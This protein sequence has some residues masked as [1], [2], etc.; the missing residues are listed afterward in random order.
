M[1]M[2]T[3]AP[4]FLHRRDCVVVHEGDAVPQH[5]PPRG[6]HQD[7]ALA[8]AELSSGLD[9]VHAGLELRDLVAV[10]V[11]V[12]VCCVGMC[13]TFKHDPQRYAP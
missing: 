9:A 4:Q 2:C 13:V 6:L 3:H 1:D 11:C 8:N 12:C 10:P 5:V 7:A